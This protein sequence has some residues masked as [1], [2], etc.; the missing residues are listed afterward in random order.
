MMLSII[1]AQGWS[2]IC[3]YIQNAMLQNSLI[4]RWGG[5]NYTVIVLIKQN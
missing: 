1:N 3:F 2:V 4:D 5:G